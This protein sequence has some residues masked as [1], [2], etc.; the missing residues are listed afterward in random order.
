M[1]RIN[2][3]NSPKW[4]SEDTQ[5]YLSNK[6]DDFKF[7]S[8]P[9]DV[10][11]KDNEGNVVINA[12]YFRGANIGATDAA[13]V[14]KNC[15]SVLEGRK[16]A[17]NHIV[18]DSLNVKNSYKAK[19]AAIKENTNANTNQPTQNNA[20][21]TTPENKD[22]TITES[23]LLDMSIFK[24]EYYDILYEDITTTDDIEKSD[25]GNAPINSNNQ[26]NQQGKAN[27]SL[28]EGAKNYKKI[29]CDVDTKMMTILDEAYDECIKFCEKVCTLK[30]K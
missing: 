14:F 9:K 2:S 25:K 19:A 24:D 12:N 8:F 23:V 10:F 20:P 26:E 18:T 29:C 27:I 16:N 15:L 4:R 11:I 13:R 7:R 22:N 17:A 30:Q 1:Q 3:Y 28:I 6:G 5:L 21:T